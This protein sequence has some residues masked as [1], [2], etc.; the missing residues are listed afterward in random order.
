MCRQS[1]ARGTD[2]GRIRARA[3]K[4]MFLNEATSWHFG[5]LLD[6]VLNRKVAIVGG[7][8]DVL[9]IFLARKEFKDEFLESKEAAESSKVVSMI[10]TMFAKASKDLSLKSGRFIERVANLKSFVSYAVEHHQQLVQGLAR[11]CTSKE[12]AP[13][14]RLNQ[15]R[16]LFS[17]AASTIAEISSS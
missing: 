16:S 13:V 14:T 6:C 1:F 12:D 7:A 17:I 9:N 5:I 15:N 8:L 10:L 2:Q 11:C 3:H 4:I